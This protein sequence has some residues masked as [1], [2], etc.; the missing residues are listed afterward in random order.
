MLSPVYCKLSSVHVIFHCRYE[1]SSVNSVLSQSILT[2]QEMS[3][4]KSIGW[5][6]AIHFA[7]EH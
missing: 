3:P 1:F 7:V 4:I 2:S 5:E 6:M